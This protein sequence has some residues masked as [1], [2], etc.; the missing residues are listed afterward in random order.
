MAQKKTFDIRNTA[1]KWFLNNEN[2]LMTV[3]DGQEAFPMTHGRFI[4]AQEV[5]GSRGVFH[6]QLEAE[7]GEE[8]V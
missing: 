5:K 1:T 7:E 2:Q 8:L 3:E 4:A 6:V